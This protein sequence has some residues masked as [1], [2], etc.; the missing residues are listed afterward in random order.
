MEIPQLHGNPGD[1][2]WGYDEETA[3]MSNIDQVV[4]S[5]EEW[6][7]VRLQESGTLRREANPVNTCQ[8]IDAQRWKVNLDHAGM[9]CESYS[10]ELCPLILSSRLSK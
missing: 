3:G 5:A 4:G 8:E 7:V 1:Q 10:T 6:I 9:H 2:S